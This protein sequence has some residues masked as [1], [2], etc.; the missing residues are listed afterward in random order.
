[1]IFYWFPMLNGR[2]LCTFLTISFISP[3]LMLTI[4]LCV[5]VFI[6]FLWI[7]FVWYIGLTTISVFI[8]AI[9]NALSISSI[10]PT[11]IGWIKFYLNL[12]P[13][14]LTLILTSNAFGGIIFGLISGYIFQY[15]HPIHLFTVLIIALLLCSI[16]FILAFS[17]Q[18]I[19][20]N[21][22]NQNKTIQQH[23]HTLLHY[24]SN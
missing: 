12:S 16:S 20:S 7:I 15:Y 1:M 23:D 6:Y 17:F 8:L 5:C 21:K 10:S 18:Y 4:S 24:Q 22:I 9:I 3:D 2:I 13:I 19:Y 11:A 14:E